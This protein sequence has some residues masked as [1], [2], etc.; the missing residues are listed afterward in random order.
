MNYKNAIEILG[1]NQK[2]TT[3][4][5]QKSY[6]GLVK[7]YHPDNNITGDEQKFMAVKE[8]YEF[9]LASNNE[10]CMENGSTYTKGYTI[11]PLCNGNGWRR[12]KIKTARGYVAQKIKC[13]ACNGVGRK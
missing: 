7:R 2:F 9:L 10:P 6:K 12:E 3:E 8:A 1:L 4:E 13:T 5:L 11:C